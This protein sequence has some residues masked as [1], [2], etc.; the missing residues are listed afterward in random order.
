MPFAVPVVWREQK[1]HITGCYLCLTKIDGHNSKSKHT[2]VYPNIPSTLR[3]VKHDDSLPVPKLTST[4]DPALRRTNQ[5]LFRRR[6]WTFIF[7]CGP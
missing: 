5:H 7:Q 2:V 6:T 4:M 1:H 3:P